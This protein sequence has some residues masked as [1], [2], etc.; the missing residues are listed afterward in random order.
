MIIKE[1]KCTSHGPFEGTHPICPAMGCESSDVVREFRTPPS[2]NSGLAKATDAS[3]NNISQ[4]YGLS[5][6]SN[7]NGKSVKENAMASNPHAAIWGRDALGSQFESMIQQGQAPVS[8]QTKDG[9]TLTAEN[10]GFK[11]A[12]E[13]AGLNKRSLPPASIIATKSD[14]KDRATVTKGAK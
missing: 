3:L 9:R 10:N 8:V 11:A 2:F 6:M 1:W 13:T 14:A 4:S 12:C 5:D 7:K